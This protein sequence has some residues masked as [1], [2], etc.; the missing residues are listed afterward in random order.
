MR[1]LPRPRTAELAASRAW[2]PTGQL[3][4]YLFLLPYLL[5]FL[6]FRLGPSIFGL[7]MSFTNW[8][9]AESPAWIGLKNFQRMRVDPRLEA[10][11]RN[12]AFFAGLTVPL[13]VVLALMLAIF[14][15]QPRRGRALGRVAVFTPYVLMSTVVGLIWT[16]ILEK[17]FGLLNVYLSHVGLE[18]VPWLVNKDYAMYGIILTTVWWTVGYDTV[19][20]LA[21]LQDIPEEL[22]EAA[23]IDGAG[24]LNIFRHITLP[25]L[26][27]TTFVVIML[28]VIN[29]FQVF[30]QVY[31][32]TSGGPGTATLT[33]VQ[34]IYTSAFQFRRMG[35]GAA[36][37]SL[38]FS[39]LIVFALLQT[40]AYRRGIKGE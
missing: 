35:Y 24:P 34:Y 13:L 36:V 17:D 23:R 27:P 1:V 30:D 29:S 32:M 33:L 14:L 9:I 38:L 11:L 21:G 31:V 22:Y 8:T 40:R 4:P 10:A 7:A 16:W 25:L 6:I 5:F 12:T 2:R 26:A 15:N 39:I 3:T 37:A 20:F 28:T 18:K 19:L